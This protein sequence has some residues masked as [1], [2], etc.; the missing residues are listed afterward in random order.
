MRI[1]NFKK[2]IL[3]F[4]FFALCFVYAGRAVLAEENCKT[5]KNYYLMLMPTQ[6]TPTAL[7]SLNQ[8]GQAF[9]QPIDT[10]EEISYDQVCVSHSKRNTC[11]ASAETISA[12]TF[13]QKMNIA[14][15]KDPVGEPIVY[16]NN[17]Y[18]FYA[19]E[20]EENGNTVVQ[21]FAHLKWRDVTNGGSTV[22]NGVNVV[23]TGNGH[24]G[25]SE[26]EFIDAMFFPTTNVSKASE[27]NALI[28]T[29]TRLADDN[30]FPTNDKKVIPFKYDWPGKTYANDD[31]K[32][33]YVAPA[34]GLAKYTVC[35]EEGGGN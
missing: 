1:K 28:W 26:S 29:I 27:S 9:F 20:P 8:T 35:T 31:E 23:T 11:P 33:T 22:G 30:M 12:S 5:Y 4:M 10:T 7:E 15:S 14:L 19:T 13:Y 34:V 17:N 21:Y 24:N 6:Y 16:K 3:V 25:A 32:N 18:E 2:I